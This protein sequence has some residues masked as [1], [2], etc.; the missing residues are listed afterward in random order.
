MERSV[1]VVDGSVIA[2]EREFEVVIQVVADDNALHFGVKSGG[3]WCSSAGV[4]AGRQGKL[5]ENGHLGRQRGTQMQCELPFLESAVGK[6]QGLGAKSAGST[7]KIRRGEIDV[8]EAGNLERRV[9][10]LRRF[11][12]RHRHRRL[13]V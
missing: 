6:H 5:S 9:N 10:W 12:L 4:I 11:G 1:P 2:A 3:R 7:M 13:V 8:A